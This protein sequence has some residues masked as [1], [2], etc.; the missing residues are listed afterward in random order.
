M[1][2]KEK[3]VSYQI[4]IFGIVQG[5]GF[6]PYVYNLAC[7]Y[8]LR[9]FVGNSGASLVTHVEGKKEN[10]KGFVL[11][12]MRHPPHLAQVENIEIARKDVVEYKEFSIHESNVLEDGSRFISPDVSVCPECIDEILDSQSRWYHYPFTNCTKCGPRYSIIE[13]LPY[14]RKNT[15]MKSFEMCP[16]CRK[17]Y[18]DPSNRRFHAQ[19]T[20]CSACGPTLS[21]RNQQGEHIECEDVIATTVRLIKRGKIVAIKGLGGYHLVC[22]AEDENAILRLR[23]RKHRPHKPLAIMAKDI[24]HITLYCYVNEEEAHLLKSNRNPIVLLH[25]KEFCDLPKIIAPDTQKLGMMLPYTPLHHLMFQQDIRFLVMTS[26]NISGAPIQYKDDEVFHAL[27]PIADYFLI[28]NRQINTPVDDSVVKVFQN[29]EIVTR[30]GRGYAPFSIK[31]GVKDGILALG[32]EQKNTFCLSKNGYG[33]TSQYL[34]DIKGF[35]TYKLY[36]NTM[37]HFNK[38]MNS[39]PTVMAYDMHPSFISRNK[40]DKF[41]G[42]KIPV[43]HHHAHMVSC[44]AEHGLK[45]PVIGVIYDGTGYGTDDNVWGGEFFVGTAKEFK[46]PGHFKYITIQGGD[47]SVKEPWRVAACYLDALGYDPRKYL[48][49][50]EQ[51]KVNVIQQALKSNINCYRSSSLGRLFDCVSAIV[52]LCHEISYEAQAAIILENIADPSIH[53]SYS[54]DVSSEGE[55]L[56]I[57]YRNLFSEVMA[58]IEYG[59]SASIISSKFHN[60][61]CNIT[62]QVVQ[63]LS[64]KYGLSEVVLSGGC[65]ENQ[66]LLNNT[67]SKLAYMG[68]KVFYNQRIPINDSGVSIGQLMIADQTV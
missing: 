25:R 12:I 2:G 7:Q 33:Y 22:N 23:L 19:P 68:M 63:A 64:N 47:Q 32:A 4:K 6:R 55:V 28:H 57:D 58:D 61:I 43:Q 39:K 20:C 10:I 37:E 56:E 14:D 42:I 45:G 11:H 60:A 24:D 8:N 36:E 41:K 65:F 21:L 13:D 30:V 46:R 52:G 54:M 3:D 34:G 40:L 29:Q 27:N 44:M 49:G 35:D 53:D 26:G 1:C 5:V 9:G 59:V 18:E 62:A 67:V 38:L 31:L 16:D 48:K 17:D 15:T 50:I 51:D 66:Y